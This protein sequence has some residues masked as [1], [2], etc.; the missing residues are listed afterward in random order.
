MISHQTTTGKLP[1]QVALIKE[2]ADEGCPF[3][4]YCSGTALSMGFEVRRNEVFESYYWKLVPD[5]TID[6]QRTCGT[7]LL[8]K[9][10]PQTNPPLGAHDTF[11]I[12]PVHQANQF[13][14]ITANSPLIMTIPK[15]NRRLLGSFFVVAVLTTN[16]HLLRISG[17]SRRIKAISMRNAS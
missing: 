10:F 6:A 1:E 13:A 8:T 5:D 12:S 16:N 3:A 2:S 15:L 9:S 7:L 14:H 11:G 17:N 4:R